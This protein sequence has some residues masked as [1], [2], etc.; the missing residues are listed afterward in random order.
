MAIALSR[1]KKP[2]CALSV[3]VGDGPYTTLVVVVVADPVQLIGYAPGRSAAVPPRSFRSMLGR[4]YVEAKF[5]RHA[6]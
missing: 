3:Q 1:N 6:R 4:A 5:K 2:S